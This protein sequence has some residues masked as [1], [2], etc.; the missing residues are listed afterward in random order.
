MLKAFLP[1]TL[2]NLTLRN[3]F[4]KTATNE[5]MWIGNL[6][7]PQLVAHHAR[8]AQGGVGLTTVAYGAVHPDGRT[9]ET[10]MYMR[11]D[12]VP[13]LK[14]LT[15]AV[16]NYGGAVSIQLT[17]CGFFTN[18]RQ[19]TGKRPAGPSRI[20]N[21]YGL[22]SGIFCSRPMTTNDLRLT[23]DDFARSARLAG[24]RSGI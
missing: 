8:L 2:R 16:H 18:N 13:G 21:N 22:L 15:E 3:R 10:Q 1:I 14:K 20:L 11:A 17:H 5:G 19:V 4:I 7:S 12:V 6:P 24:C 9:H 23:T